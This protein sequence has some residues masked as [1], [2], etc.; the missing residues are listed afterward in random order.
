[1]VCIET[2]R[3]NLAGFR[4]TDRCN[5]HLFNA[6]FKLQS[7]SGCSMNMKLLHG[8]LGDNFSV[9][10]SYSTNDVNTSY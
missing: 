5:F 2:A 9:P 1:M 10:E 7:R 6:A 8:S 3:F 4:P